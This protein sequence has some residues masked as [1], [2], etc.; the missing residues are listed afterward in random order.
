MKCQVPEIE[1]QS[2]RI[3]MEPYRYSQNNLTVNHL[4]FPK[5]ISSAMSV[6]TIDNTV[7]GNKESISSSKRIV[8]D[9][10]VK[11]K[12]K[13]KNNENNSVTIIKKTKVITGEKP[14]F[15]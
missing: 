12:R 10:S 11:K 2:S 5:N 13:G 3:S 9:K 1:R 4:L 15:N 6:L 8:S 7:R 14:L